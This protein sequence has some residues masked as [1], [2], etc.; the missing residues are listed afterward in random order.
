MGNLIPNE[1]LIYERDDKDRIYAR[2]RD[3]PEIPRWYIV[4]GEQGPLFEF[5]A[6]KEMIEL[7]EQHP[8]LKKRL[9]QALDLFY[10]LKEPNEDH[11]RT[12]P[13]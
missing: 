13:T 12:M 7:A 10:I 6:W 4:G 3:R 8:M 5:T 9:D 11:S 2:Y 1:A